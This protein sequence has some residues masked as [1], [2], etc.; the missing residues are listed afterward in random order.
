M[1]VLISG[2]LLNGAGQAMA[3]CHIILKSLVNT[4]E[5][6]MRTIADVVVGGD[7]EYAFNAQT[8]K[9]CVYMRRGWCEDEYYVGE[10][11]IREGSAPGTLNDYLVALNEDDLTPDVIKRF[12]TLA[13]QVKQDA[14]SVAEARGSVETLAAEVK[15]NADSVLAAETSVSQL[16]QEAASSARAAEQSAQAAAQGVEDITGAVKTAQQAASESAAS[17][18]ASAASAGN[19]AECERNAR[20]N[21]QQTAQ[22]LQGAVTARN[23]AER[24]AT[25]SGQNAASTAADRTAT[26]GDVKQSGR[27]AAAS[28]QNALEAKGYRDSAQQIVQS[29]N[30]TSA[31]TTQK[32]LVQLSSATDSDSEALA[33][34]PLAV[35]MVMDEVQT[36]AAVES[37]A[38]TGTPT[39]PTPADDAAGLEMANAA[40]VRKLISALVGSSPEALDTLNELAAALGN[41][42]NFATTITNAL[43]GKQP[44][45][46]VLTAVSQITPRA[47]N[48]PYFGTEG[49][50]LLEELSNKARGLISLGTLE[51]MRA[52]LELKAAATMEPQSDIRD[53]TEGRLAIP[54]TFGYGHSF[55]ESERVN[56]SADFDE[57]VGWAL[58]VGPGLYYVQA[59]AN[60]I[61]NEAVSGELEIISLGASGLLLFFRNSVYF[62]R[63]IIS[64]RD[65][66]TPWQNVSYEISA[67]YSTTGNSWGSPGI[68]GLMLAAYC[69]ESDNDNNRKLYRGKVVPGS[70]LSQ[71]S[72]T[73]SYSPTGTYVSSARLAVTTPLQYPQ[74][75]SFM[76]LSGSTVSTGG[77]DTSMIGLFMRIA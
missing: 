10:I 19:A 77:S 45:N 5:V 8:G 60:V 72:L 43:A 13:A 55:T 69:G 38:F 67:L 74:S 57:F 26:A 30:E 25:E 23:D 28:A 40:F 76:A 42:P 22:D 9:Y 75:G 64:D 21:A 63:C 31:S 14:S 46:D 20:Q 68:G 48:F 47:N 34:T 29:L 37:P 4:S 66:F 54:G 59:P 56:L 15:T 24:F 44:L 33:A 16:A 2:T 62:K 70:R 53:R 49:S 3:G 6:I 39:T 11:T 58:S 50:V 51:K 17:A 61:S 73:G 27:N 35:K 41:D 71:I 52:Y 18:G 36:K 7:G 65:M 32:G 12:E 1:S